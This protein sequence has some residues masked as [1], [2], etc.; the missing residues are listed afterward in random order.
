VG[1]DVQPGVYETGI[2]TE[3]LGCQWQ[4]LSG[5]SGAPDEVLASG[6]VANH[7]V[8]EILADDAAFDTNCDAWYELSGIDRPMTTIPEGKWVVN[9][10]IESGTFSAPGGN[11]CSWARLSGLTGT[12][13]EV[14]E[15]D[16][17]TGPPT[18][19]I[20]PSDVAFTSADCGEWHLS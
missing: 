2:V 1:E 10:H 5:T 16:T 17:P 18:V 13:E 3:L 12:E 6:Q 8:V 15:S 7:D 9:T 20:E 19:T 4:R 14:I 11:E